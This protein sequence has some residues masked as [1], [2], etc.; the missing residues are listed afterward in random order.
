MDLIVHL[1]YFLLRSRPVA[2][3]EAGPMII[4]TQAT[5]TLHPVVIHSWLECGFFSLLGPRHPDTRAGFS[6]KLLGQDDNSFSPSDQLS[7]VLT[8]SALLYRIKPAI[9]PKG[10]VANLASL[11]WSRSGLLQSLSRLSSPSRGVHKHCAFRSS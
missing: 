4:D 11:T 2:T 9:S 6:R 10:Y 5:T 8:A 7:D 3:E 1:L